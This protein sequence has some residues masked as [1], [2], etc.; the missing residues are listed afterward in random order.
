MQYDAASRRSKLIHPNGVTTD[1]GYDERSRLATLV[2]DAPISPTLESLEWKGIPRDRFQ[3]W[4]A[5]I[6]TR[7]TLDRAA[8]LPTI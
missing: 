7:D 1:Y 4:C 3:A 6:G 2:E 8:R 5:A